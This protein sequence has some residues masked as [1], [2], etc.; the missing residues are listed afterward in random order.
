[1]F[2]VIQLNVQKYNLQSTVLR[3]LGPSADTQNKKEKKINS[4]VK[5]ELEIPH[6]QTIHIIHVDRDSFLDPESREVSLSFF[7]KN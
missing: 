4:K 6:L 5:P 1:M 7:L 2:R 3:E